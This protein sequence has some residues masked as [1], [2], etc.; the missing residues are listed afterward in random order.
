MD[1]GTLNHRHEF[2]HTGNKYFGDRIMKLLYGTSSV[3]ESS[4]FIVG[5]LT[6]GP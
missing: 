3:K 1:I 4:K 2:E 5:K 6:L